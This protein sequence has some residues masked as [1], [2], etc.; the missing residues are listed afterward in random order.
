MFPHVPALAVRRPRV[1]MAPRAIA[2]ATVTRTVMAVSRVRAGRRR[3]DDRDV[4][5]ASLLS[6]FGFPLLPGSMGFRPGWF[7]AG[8]RSE[9]LDTPAPML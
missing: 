2:A 4:R 1:S 6:T 3:T 7:P 9:R 5:I 8:P